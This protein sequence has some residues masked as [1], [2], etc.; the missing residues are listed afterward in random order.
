MPLVHAW[1]ELGAPMDSTRRRI[2]PL[3][4]VRAKKAI[5]EAK[6]IGA[7]ATSARNRAVLVTA[8]A[9]PGAFY[10]AEVGGMPED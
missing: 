6:S 3:L 2:A 8:R 4:R 10:G 5:G 9:S 7:L 1:R